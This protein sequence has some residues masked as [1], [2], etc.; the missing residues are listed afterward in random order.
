MSGGGTETTEVD[1][2]STFD[3]RVG[4]GSGS[5]AIVGSLTES[6]LHTDVRVGSIPS[7]VR[8]DVK[9]RR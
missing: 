8:E 3:R 9:H 2:P 4:P 6:L 1:E 7:S 5:V